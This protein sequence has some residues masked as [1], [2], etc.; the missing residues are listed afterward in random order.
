MSKSIK[1]E[2]LSRI[3]SLCKFDNNIVNINSR[4]LNLDTINSLCGNMIYTPY[5][6][7]LYN[8]CNI[9]NISFTITSKSIKEKCLANI[10]FDI[11]QKNISCEV[12]SSLSIS[13]KVSKVCEY[14]LLGTLSE[15][16]CKLKYTELISAK[17]DCNIDYNTYVDLVK[18][19]YL[20]ETI[21][22]LVANNIKIQ[23]KPGSKESYLITISNNTYSKND[24]CFSDITTSGVTDV[25]SFLQNH[26][27]DLDENLKSQIIN[28]ITI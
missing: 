12:L 17:S 19:G 22:I 3:F 2:V 27:D 23:T 20:P 24:L 1:N 18:L 6:Q 10:S 14:T 26:I 15:T 28:S 13:E 9:F 8:L 16:T 25:K 4:Y 11:Q 7:A 5:E 21:N